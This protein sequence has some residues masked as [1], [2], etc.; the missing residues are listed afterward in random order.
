MDHR[1]KAGFLASRGLK[2]AIGVG[3]AIAAATAVAYVAYSKESKAEQQDAE[4]NDAEKSE[5]NKNNQPGRVPPPTQ[6]QA[7]R[8]VPTQPNKAAPLPQAPANQDPRYQ[9]LITNLRPVVQREV[10]SGQLQAQTIMGINEALTLV[11]QKPFGDAIL[12]NRRDRR[13]VRTTDEAEYVNIVQRGTYEIENVVNEKLTE[14]LRDLGCTL[15]MYEQSNEV[16]AR[17]NPNFAFISLLMIE[18][19]KT[20]INSG[21][22]DL[23]ALNVDKAREMIQFQIDNY[24]NIDIEC[25]NPQLKPLVKQSYLGDLTAEKFGFEEED[26]TKVQGLS[27]DSTF[28][29]L[30]MRLQEVVQRDAMGAMGGG[31]F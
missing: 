28:R 6:P 2:I 18:K 3:V 23:S 10:A 27:Q 13:A 31:M 16:W 17:Q 22:R 29:E 1:E 26:I 24:P 12:N 9:A 7:N 4:Q 11:A 5:E 20:G 15:A 19:M 25:N 30:A 8:P 21:Q 14:V